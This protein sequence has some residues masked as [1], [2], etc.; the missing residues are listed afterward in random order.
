MHAR[1]TSTGT[2]AQ[3]A[4]VE[5]TVEFPHCG[6]VVRVPG[7][8]E[9]T[10]VDCPLCV[11]YRWTADEADTLVDAVSPWGTAVL[12]LPTSHQPEPSARVEYSAPHLPPFHAS[13]LTPTGDLLRILEAAF[14][15]LGVLLEGFSS[16]LSALLGLPSPPDNQKVLAAPERPCADRPGAVRHQKLSRRGRKHVEWH[17][18]PETRS[19]ATRSS[20]P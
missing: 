10:L 4:Q 6:H 13:R 19:I 8:A 12:P 2:P 1:S 14:N 18:S 9:R 7:N 5:F 20:R 15:V 16:V 17:S 11:S 3:G